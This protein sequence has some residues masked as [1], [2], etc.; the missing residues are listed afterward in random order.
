MTITLE[1]ENTSITRNRFANVSKNTPTETDQENA[2]N[3]RAQVFGMRNKRSVNAPATSCG[4]KR[5]RNVNVFTLT[6]LTVMETA[7]TVSSQKFGTAKIRS[8]FALKTCLTS[9][10]IPATNARKLKNTTIMASATFALKASP[11]IIMDAAMCAQKTNLING[12]RT[13]NATNAP[14]LLLTTTRTRSAILAL[15]TMSHTSMTDAATDA[16]KVNNTIRL[17]ESVLNAEEEKT[18]GKATRSATNAKKLSLN[19]MDAAMSAPNK[20]LTSTTANAT[21][22]LN[23]S[24][25]TREDATNVLKINMKSTENV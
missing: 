13:A 23:S 17:I 21:N 5:N 12:I 22:A 11:I 20:L 6:V 16:L 2:E 18:T 10:I 4:I 3:A 8:V 15:K 24:S 9:M 19:I 25:N 1:Q 7:K 14:F